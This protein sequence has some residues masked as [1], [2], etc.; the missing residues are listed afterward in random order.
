MNRG[1]SAIL[2]V[3][4]L[5]TSAACTSETVKR[6][7]YEALRQKQCTDN[8]RGLACDPAHEP[9]EQYDKDREAALKPDSG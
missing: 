1:A 6:G 9:Y 2:I 5:A 7:T 8:A 4:L 3:L